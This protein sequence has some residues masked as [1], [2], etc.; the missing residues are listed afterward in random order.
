MK[1]RSK[2]FEVHTAFFENCSKHA[3]SLSVRASCMGL[4]ATVHDWA[5]S[6]LCRTGGSNPIKCMLKPHRS[7]AVR[8]L[9]VTDSL[10]ATSTAVR[11][12]AERFSTFTSRMHRFVVVAWAEGVA[13]QTL[14]V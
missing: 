14:V 7:N 2:V 3:M 12:V 4:V 8:A 1:R 9:C 10:L 5:L 6:S 11:S 13:A